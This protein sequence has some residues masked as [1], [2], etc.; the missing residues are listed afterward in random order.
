MFCCKIAPDAV[1]EEVIDIL[2]DKFVGIMNEYMI[3]IDEEDK[4]EGCFGCPSLYET[5]QKNKK[6]LSGEL[7]IFT[8]E[9]YSLPMVNKEFRIAGE[10]LKHQLYKRLPSRFSS[11]KGVFVLE[12]DFTFR[13]YS[14]KYDELLYI[15]G[16]LNVKSVKVN[17]VKEEIKTQDREIGF[18][19]PE[20]CPLP[21]IL[22]GVSIPKVDVS[23]KDE[24]HKKMELGGNGVSINK[25]Y[26]ALE[27]AKLLKMNSKKLCYYY[28]DGW[29]SIIERRLNGYMD[30]THRSE[31]SENQQ[32]GAKLV[33][34]GLDAGTHAGSENKIIYEYTFEYHPLTSLRDKRR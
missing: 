10:P 30:G 14:A 23:I 17:I 31:V 7:H 21:G 25:N 6:I 34:M 2:D 3:L 8:M 4:K 5:I 1:I 28:R 24:L 9:Q 16:I 18:Q 32:F 12:S 15:L 29:K 19:M 22:P 33:S 26:T 13:D 11:K 20:W 27:M